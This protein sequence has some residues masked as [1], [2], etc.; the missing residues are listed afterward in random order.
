MKNKD[1]EKPATEV[2]KLQNTGILMDSKT[3]Q[4]QA[5]IATMNGQFT[6]ED[7]PLP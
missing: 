7:I 6:E 1:Y 4:V 3:Q 2:V 5:L